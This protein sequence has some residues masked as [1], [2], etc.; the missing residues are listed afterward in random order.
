MEVWKLLLQGLFLPYIRSC[1]L[2]RS[3]KWF[4]EL[5]KD[6][7]TRCHH[8]IFRSK[9][10]VSAEPCPWPYGYL[11]LFPLLSM[12]QNLIYT[13]LSINESNTK[14][15][16]HSAPMPAYLWNHCG[17]RPP[18]YSDPAGAVIPSPNPSSAHWNVVA[19]LGWCD[20]SPHW[21][22]FPAVCGSLAVSS[23]P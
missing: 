10:S 5:S 2:F 17:I 14:V 8:W 16:W 22:K 13:L 7:V 11:G 4:L 15:K 23:S 19:L 1:L 9:H 12:S 3:K 20:L 6:A 18:K 21:G